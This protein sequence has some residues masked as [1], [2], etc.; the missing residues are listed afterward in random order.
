MAKRRSTAPPDRPPQSTPQD[1]PPPPLPPCPECGSDAVSV[2]MQTG[3][4]AYLQCGDCTRSWQVPRAA[5]E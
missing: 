3:E 4:I 2:A 1:V 5:V